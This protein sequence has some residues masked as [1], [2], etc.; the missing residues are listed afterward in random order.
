MQVLVQ[1]SAEP[2]SSAY[3]E[4]DDPFWI[5]DRNR[6]GAQWSGLRKGL[7]GPMPVV[8]LLILAQGMTQICGCRN[9]SVQVVGVI[10]VRMARGR[11]SS[12]MRRPRHDG[13]PCWCAWLTSP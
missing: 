3:V 10:D 2:A 7:V 1:D 4:V 5:H 11:G 6:D 13:V 12:N 8:E 9:S